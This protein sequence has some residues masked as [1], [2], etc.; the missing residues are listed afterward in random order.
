MQLVLGT[1]AQF[2]ELRLEETVEIRSEME[3][4]EGEQ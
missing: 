1:W 4:R 3:E 2:Q